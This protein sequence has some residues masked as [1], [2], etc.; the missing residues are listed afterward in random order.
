[1]PLI[2]REKVQGLGSIIHSISLRDLFAGFVCA[3]ICANP[4]SVVVSANT[5]ATYAY[6]IADALLEERK[7]EK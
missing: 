5:V 4:D 7:K 3:G 2:D 6:E 1:M